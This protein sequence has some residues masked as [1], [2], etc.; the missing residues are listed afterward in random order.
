MGPSTLYPGVTFGRY[1]TAQDQ[2]IPSS[3]QSVVSPNE[4]SG[5]NLQSSFQP[6]TVTQGLAGQSMGSPALYQGVGSSSYESVL[7]QSILSSSQFSQTS[8]MDF[9]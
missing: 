1:T 7:D 6:S 5:F 3:S 2:S 8:T 9:K 4:S